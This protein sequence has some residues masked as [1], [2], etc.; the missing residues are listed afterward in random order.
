LRREDLKMMEQ[1]VLS[2]KKYYQAMND[3]NVATIEKLLHPDVQFISPMVQA[4]GKE[5]MLGVMSNF[6]KLFKTLTIDT[7]FGSGNQ[8]IV[9]Y[10]LDC[11]P[12]VGTF[13]TAA[14]MTFQDGLIARI[15]A[16]YDARHW[17]KFPCNNSRGSQ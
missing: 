4:T 9:I 5:K 1:N 6:G 15:E 14:F 16:F 7:A 17:E 12:P 3:R 2:A 8:V 13:R 10:D 11:Q